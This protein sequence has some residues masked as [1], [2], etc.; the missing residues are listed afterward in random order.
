MLNSFLKILEEVIYNRLLELVI[1]NNI[2]AKEQFGFRKNL[3]T[4]KVTY[5]LSNKI[6]GILDKK[7]Y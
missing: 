4:E 1:N 7:N 2:L 5:K 3:R 6:T